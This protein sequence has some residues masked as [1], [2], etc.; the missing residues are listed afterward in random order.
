MNTPIA[1]VPAIPALE[2]NMVDPPPPPS[3]AAEPELEED[4]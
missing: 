4:N 3:A 1:M 2:A